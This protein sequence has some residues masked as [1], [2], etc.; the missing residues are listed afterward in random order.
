MYKTSELGNPDNPDDIHNF[1][2]FDKELGSY[3]NS[4]VN[5]KKILILY[6]SGSFGLVRKALKKST[7][8]DF[9]IKIIDK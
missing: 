9:A 5:R 4:T 1:Y 6:Y 2:R 8:E 3:N 7:G